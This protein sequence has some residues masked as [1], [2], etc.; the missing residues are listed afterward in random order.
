MS[1]RRPNKNL[2]HRRWSSGRFWI[3]HLNLLR[4]TDPN[5]SGFMPIALGSITP[6][7][8]LKSGGKHKLRVRSFIQTTGSGNSLI[9][10]VLSPTGLRTSW[11]CD[12]A[13]VMEF[14]VGFWLVTTRC[15]TATDKSCVATLHVPIS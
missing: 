10:P 9:L 8:V 3:S 4:Y 1:A 5:A 6:A 11:N 13:E 14:I 12:Y 2:K 15:A 7:L